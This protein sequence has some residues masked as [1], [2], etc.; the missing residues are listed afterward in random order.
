MMTSARYVF[1]SAVIGIFILI[2]TIISASEYVPPPAGPYESALTISQ[3]ADSTS[4]ETR[5]YK[6]PPS[7]LVEKKVPEDLSTVLENDLKKSKEIITTDVDHAPARY[8]QNYIDQPSFQNGNQPYWNGTNSGNAAHP[9]NPSPG[10]SG[11]RKF[12]Y[13]RAASNPWQNGQYSYPQG[14]QYNYQN[15]YQNNPGNYNNM[16]NGPFNAM[17]SPWSGMPMPGFFSGK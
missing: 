10:Q 8:K 2:P 3:T 5:V 15:N 6:F 9:S 4:K 7:D 16:W 1:L 13:P 14:Y 11:N 12:R 17:N